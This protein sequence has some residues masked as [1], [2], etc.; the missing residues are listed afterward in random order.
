MTEDLTKLVLVMLAVV[1]TALPV[2]YTVWFKWHRTP[3]GRGLFFQALALALVVDQAVLRQIHGMK[4]DGL[5]LAVFAFLL[6]TQTGILVEM[7][8]VK[9]R[10]RP[11]DGVKERDSGQ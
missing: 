11:L 3:I 7:V 6:V 8:R 5:R 1:C 9:A 10:R 2:L 4:Y